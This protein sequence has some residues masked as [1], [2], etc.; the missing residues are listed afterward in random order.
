M[1]DFVWCTLHVLIPHHPYVES[2]IC[3]I[4]VRFFDNI[5]GPFF[6][7]GGVKVFLTLLPL[8]KRLN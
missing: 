7:G 4:F 6:G 5:S 3:L 1:F 8:S 2:N